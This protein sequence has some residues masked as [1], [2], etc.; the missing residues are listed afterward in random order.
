MVQLRVVPSSSLMQ[1]RNPR[2]T[3]S[4]PA[5]TVRLRE[6]S[7]LKRVEWET[8]GYL[9]VADIFNEEER[10]ELIEATDEL[11]EMATSKTESDTYFML[12]EGHSSGKPMLKRSRIICP[13]LVHPVWHKALRHPKLLDII[14]Q[15]IGSSSIRHLKQEKIHMK[16]PG[17]DG[18]L[19][20]KW[21]QDWAFFPH[22]NDSLV[23]VGIAVDD[24]TKENGPNNTAHTRRV[25]FIQYAA[26]DAWPLTGVVGPEGYA[27]VEGPVDWERFCS[28]IVRGSPTVYPRMVNIPISLPFPYDENVDLF[29]EQEN[30]KEQDAA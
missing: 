2:W 22:T 6:V 16:M 13:S 4:G 23:T 12:E 29:Y 15:L 11:F 30:K 18:S 27:G 21:H 17:K 20:I 25:C 8:N 3:P 9:A 28:T 26:T 14:S 24:S 1:S 19:G 7:A 5:A 10:K